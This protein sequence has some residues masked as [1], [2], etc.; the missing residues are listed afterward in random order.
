VQ[1]PI[2]Q[3]LIP[4]DICKELGVKPGSFYASVQS[5]RNQGQSAPLSSCEP[6]PVEPGE[7][8]QV[9]SVSNLKKE[10]RRLREQLRRNRAL[11][12]TA[13]ERDEQELQKSKI[14]DALADCEI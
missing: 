3:E 14:C 2:F 5:A 7:L 11:I 1:N 6:E 10:N 8:L 12:N 13:R 9:T 4:D